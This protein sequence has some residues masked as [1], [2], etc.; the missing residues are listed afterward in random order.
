[1]DHYLD[2]RLLADPEFSVPILMNALY[3]KLHRTLVALRANNIG[4]S[5]PGYQRKPITLGNT[6]RLHG[7]RAALVGLQEADWLKGIRDHTTVSDIQP[8]PSVVR[9][10]QINR[11]QYKTSAERLRKRRMKRKGETYEQASQAIPESVERQ[12]GLPFLTLR[13][14]STGQVFRLFVDQGPAQDQPVTG[15]FNSYGISEQ[16]TVP[17][18]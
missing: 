6:L 8:V 3:S 12:P 13:S 5:F 14:V 16:A 4:V 17:C 7:S 18:F 2:I 10:L 15:D 1:M 11:R 9:Y